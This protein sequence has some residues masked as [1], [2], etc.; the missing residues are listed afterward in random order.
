MGKK[1][2]EEYTEKNVPWVAMPV[3]MFD[4][5]NP[6]LFISK[7]DDY[8]F[9]LYFKL[10]KLTQNPWNYGKIVTSVALLSDQMPIVADKTKNRAEYKRLLT[11]LSDRGYI[12]IAP[13][14]YKN[15]TPLTIEVPNAVNTIQNEEK[16]DE[17]K[18][19]KFNRFV[20]VEQKDY[21]AC[22]GNARYFRAWIYAEHRM[23]RGKKNEGGWIFYNKEWQNVM[24]IQSKTT[25]VELF[26]EMQSLNII[27]KIQG[28]TYTDKNGNVKN[29]GSRYIPVSKGIR[30]VRQEQSE[31]KKKGEKLAESQNRVV[32][33]LATTMDVTDD[34][35]HKTNLMN[36]DKKVK[37]TGK[38]I[39]IYLDT[40]CEV[41]KAYVK[42]RLDGLEKAHPEAYKSLMAAGHKEYDKLKQE[43]AGKKWVEERNNIK[44]SKEEIDFQN[45]EVVYKKKSNGG[46]DLSS[47]LD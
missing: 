42:K 16:D 4:F 43:R 2:S 47:I 30:D 41:T 35:V 18:K 39:A 20:Q 31:G 15:D 9:N 12:K 29:E 44:V 24:D 7:E 46:V 8:A 13:S 32:D 6:S 34:R 22:Q 23:F 28:K 5:Q 14:D 19:I 37:L 21:E 10:A 17:G 27:D 38:D 1:D 11:V 26:K 36:P 3:Q 33:A 25:I 45:T 40:D